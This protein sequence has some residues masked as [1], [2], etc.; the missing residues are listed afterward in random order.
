MK[1]EDDFRGLLAALSNTQGKF[2]GF[3]CFYGSFGLAGDYLLVNVSYFQP[4]NGLEKTC[5]VVTAW[6]IRKLQHLL[7]DFSIELRRDAA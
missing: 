2:L 1:V 4:D 6:E 3:C 5:P 7:G